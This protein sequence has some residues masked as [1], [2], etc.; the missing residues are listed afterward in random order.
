MVAAL[1]AVLADVRAEF[2][3]LVVFAVEQ[4]FVVDELSA[5]ERGAL[6]VDVP[7]G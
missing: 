4:V 7:T 3:F 6:D 1:D 2:A 5:D